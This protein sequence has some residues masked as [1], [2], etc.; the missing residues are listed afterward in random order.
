M[1]CI[2]ALATCILITH[3]AGVDCIAQEVQLSSAFRCRK[4]YN[5]FIKYFA[6]IFILII[7]FSSIVYVFGLI[8]M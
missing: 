8:S 6:P 3:V 1:C 5:V 4:M 7:L 2:A